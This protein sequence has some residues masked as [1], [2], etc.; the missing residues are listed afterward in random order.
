MK[1]KTWKLPIHSGHIS[2]SRPIIL[3]GGG[4]E[5]GIVFGTQIM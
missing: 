3:V 5:E 1:G 4:V 2:K